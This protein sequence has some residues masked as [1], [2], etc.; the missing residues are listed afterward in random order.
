LKELVSNNEKENIFIEKRMQ[1]EE[2]IR[3][4]EAI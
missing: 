3:V 1:A 4:Q 2:N